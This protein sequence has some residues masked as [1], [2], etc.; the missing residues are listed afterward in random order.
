MAIPRTG[1]WYFVGLCLSEAAKG[2]WGRADAITSIVGAVIGALLHY[3]PRWE[4]VVTHSLWA[5]PFLSLAAVSLFRLVMSPYWVYRHAKVRASERE[6][7]LEKILKHNDAEIAEL[8]YPEDRPKISFAG[9]GGPLSSEDA[10][11]KGFYLNN[12]GGAA[13]EV[14]VER[15]YVGSQFTAVGS[16]VSRVDNKRPGFAPV[17]LEDEPQLTKWALDTALQIT[18]K[19]KI[20]CGELKDSQPLVIPM[21]VVYRDFN[22]LWYRSVGGLIF[23]D[24]KIGFMAVQQKRFG[25]TRP[26]PLTSGLPGCQ[27]SAIA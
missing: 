6:Q 20:E 9:W 25:R 3:V 22:D 24:G 21:S 14:Q 4:Q 17:W 8:T 2:T 16:T 26:G 7:E 1:F 15:F 10:E 13:L 11:R 18:L 23:T 19:T 27:H 5:I 12:D